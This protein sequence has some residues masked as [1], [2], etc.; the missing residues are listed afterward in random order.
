MKCVK[1]ELK[2]A[3][4]VKN[5]LIKL[6]VFDNNFSVSR[7][8]NY[9]Y[10][11]VNKKVNGF[12]IVNKTLIKK[13]I[14]DSLENLLKNKLNSYE[15]KE[16]YKSYDLIGNIAILEISD[17]LLKKK[18]IIAQALL[19]SNKTIK[20]VVRKIGEHKGEYRIQDYELLAGIK[21]FNIFYKENGV[22]VKFDIRKVYFSPR[23]SNERLR[24][25][26]QV[27]E[28]EFVLVMFSGVGIYN[29]VIAKHS[30][31]KDIY[32]I[33]INPEGYKYSEESLKLNKFSNIKF[34]CGDVRIVLPKLKKKFDR[35][36]MP[37]PHTSLDFLDLALKYLNKKGV[38]HL[39]YFASEEDIIKIVENI[40]NK[41]KCKIFNVIKCGQQ[42]PRIYRFCIDFKV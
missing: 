34:Y 42:S 40:K 9:V 13:E 14:I 20:T 7:D 12:K 41:I 5:K 11:P 4:R 29:F 15:F 21:N 36:V 22:N 18:K 19:K 26:K 8:K 37:L 1:V 25:A 31:A 6:N 2:Q 35:I 27:T 28:G 24:V 39:Y 32:G 10:F 23:L 33:E 30:K 16:L 17:K 38:I 3:E